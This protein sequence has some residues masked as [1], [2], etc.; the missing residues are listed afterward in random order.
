MTTADDSMHRAALAYAA[1][2]W[3]VLPMQPRA[4][5]PLVA[6]TVHQHR[7]ATREQIDRWW[8]RWPDANVGLVT[9][10]V[11]GLVVVDVDAGHGGLN[12]LQALQQRHGT[13]PPT[14][15]AVTGGGGRHLYFRHP[16]RA[17]HNR[18]GMHPGIDLRADGG[19]VVAPPS[20]H[21]NGRRYAW[22]PGHGPGEVEPAELPAWLTGEADGAPAGHAPAHWRELLRQGV[23]EGARNATLASLAGHLLRQGVDAQV[24]LELLSAWNRERC[25]P[26]L[27]DNEV[28]RVLRSIA[29]LHA[30]PD[31]T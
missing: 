28:A 12:S 9:G 25:R 3:S 27:P 2:G 7:A 23:A 30:R 6:W 24:A 5:R 8:R 19:C 1:R 17:L 31:Q 13:L 16:G 11:S 26:P 29:R 4:K 22:L 14:I 20:V 18:V 10:S 21:P 15:E